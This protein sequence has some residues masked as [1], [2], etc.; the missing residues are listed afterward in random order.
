MTINH[1]RL[2]IE[3]IIE[4]SQAS[5][6]TSQLYCVCCA[7]SDVSIKFGRYRCLPYGWPFWRTKKRSGRY[8]LWGPASVSKCNPCWHTSRSRMCRRAWYSWNAHADWRNRWYVWLSFPTMA[9]FPFRRDWTC[10]EA[11]TQRT[12][13]RA[14]KM[15]ERQLASS[16]TWSEWKVS[17]ECT[18]RYHYS[19]YRR[20]CLL[21]FAFDALPCYLLCLMLFCIVQTDGLNLMFCIISMCD[22]LCHV[23]SNCICYLS[24]GL[25]VLT[26][27]A[28]PCNWYKFESLTCLVY[29]SNYVVSAY[30]LHCIVMCSFASAYT[31]HCIA[32]QSCIVA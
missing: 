20:P 11:T 29:V 23:D 30:G 8:R 7:P 22:A 9:W 27:T 6:H 24:H 31:W 17:N 4:V 5:R 16:N 10:N 1:R 19:Y 32:L 21:S 2:L 15:K 13:A 3:S 14:N 12:S 28:F 25:H 18:I 26:C